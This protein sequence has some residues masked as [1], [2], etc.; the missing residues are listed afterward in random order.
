M[1]RYNQAVFIIGEQYYQL[2]MFLLL[3]GQQYKQN[4]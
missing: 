4:K 3:P 2:E 1:L